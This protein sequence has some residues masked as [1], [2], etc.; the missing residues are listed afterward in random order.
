MYL[1]SILQLCSAVAMIEFKVKHSFFALGSR[2]K[3]KPKGFPALNCLSRSRLQ[4][5]GA[6]MNFC[7]NWRKKRV[8]LLHSFG[9]LPVTKVF[10][11]QIW[12]DISV[13]VMIQLLFDRK[14][15]LSKKHHVL[16]PCLIKHGT[17]Q[18]FEKSF[19]RCFTNDRLRWRPLQASKSG[20]KFKHG[21]CPI[22]LTLS[23]RCGDKIERKSPSPKKP[24]LSLFC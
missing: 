10:F 20:G 11:V 21:R 13:E 15:Q 1:D 24:M 3:N 12:V 7:E 18:N 6:W 2:E 16:C 9:D 23:F 8:T 19:T 17:F 14:A 22:F 4:V 5:R